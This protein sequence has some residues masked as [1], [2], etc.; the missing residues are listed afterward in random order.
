M[1]NIK[2]VKKSQ[3]KNPKVSLVLLD[4]SVRESFHLFHYL[5]KQ[6]VARDEFEVIVIENY[7]RVSDALS[8]FD[9]QVDTWVTLGMPEDCYYHKHLMYNVGIAFS[10]GNIIMIG[11]SDAMVKESFIETVIESFEANPSMAFHM[12]QFRNTRRDFYPFNYPSFEDVIEDGCINNA[13]GKTVG[14][15]NTTDPIHSRN[16]GACMCARREDLI[17]IGGADEHIDFLGHIC[18]P[19]DMTFRLLNHGLQEVWHQNEFLYHTWHPGQAGADNYMGPHDGKHMSTTSLEALNSGRIQPHVENSVIRELREGATLSLDEMS[20]R[21]IDPD[22]LI[23]WN[24]ALIDEMAS[25]QKWTNYV[26][27]M[28]HY[29]GFR[30]TIEVDRLIARPLSGVLIP[31]FE[32][33]GGQ[34]LVEAANLNELRNK[35]DAFHKPELIEAAAFACRNFIPT[36]AVVWVKILIRNVLAHGYRAAKFHDK[37]SLK[38]FAK[39]VFR[40]PRDIFYAPRDFQEFVRGTKGMHG[41]LAAALY[42]SFPKNQNK[43]DNHHTPM[44]LVN[45]RLTFRF[46]EELRARIGITDFKIQNIKD[47]SSLQESLSKI[48]KESPQG[49]MI[50]WGDLYSKFHDTITSS[51]KDKIKIVV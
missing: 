6:T 40:L 35:I 17:A 39:V 38:A 36:L 7:G 50:V 44:V 24:T 48:E 20:A 12:D 9:D 8:K 21:L 26:V 45:N 10:R 3:R 2:F 11:D 15:L 13:N 47:I 19:Y 1:N 41:S 29:N 14:I 30:I 16:Y 28:G 25:H 33:N 46:L 32:V 27:S 5:S 37:K 23:N 31:E 42:Y 34:Q 43:M 22:Y 18:G 4:W 49:A 51:C